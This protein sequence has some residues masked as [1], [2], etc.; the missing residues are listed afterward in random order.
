MKFPS[1]CA[2]FAGFLLLSMEALALEWCGSKSDDLVLQTVKVNP[3][4]IERS[5]GVT[6]EL[7][8]DLHKPI[9]PDAYFFYD[10][11]GE[12][13]HE[14]WKSAAVTTLD[15]A[16]LIPDSS[17]ST[18]RINP[19]FFFPPE[20]SDVKKNAEINVHIV[21]RQGPSDDSKRIFCVQGTLIL[22]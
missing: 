16:D 12:G 21:A 13:N 7:V 15:A 4:P 9:G 3:N 22:G 1:A 20:F 14:V 5:K 19:R 11:R 2:A 17:T 8:G 6:L 10:F 18:K